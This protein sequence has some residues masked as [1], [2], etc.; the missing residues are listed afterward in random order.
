MDARR[1]PRHPRSRERAAPTGRDGKAWNS[2]S[3]KL[4][5]LGRRTE[6]RDKNEAGFRRW[7]WKRPERREHQHSPSHLQRSRG[8]DK[9]TPD[10]L[11]IQKQPFQDILRIP[12][13]HLSLHLV[14]FLT[15]DKISRNFQKKKKVLVEEQPLGKFVIR[16]GR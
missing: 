1:P 15:A 5:S 10:P 6:E 8:F 9:L 11:K 14:F 12:M 4:P 3:A 2:T 16:S 7:E 13:Y